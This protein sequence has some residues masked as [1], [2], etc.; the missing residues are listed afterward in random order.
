[1]SKA[2]NTNLV[3]TAPAPVSRK[4]N[5]QT[6]D[7]FMTNQPS[8]PS[9]LSAKSSSEPETSISEKPLSQSVSPDASQFDIGLHYE[10][11]KT[12]DDAEK[13]RL[14]S[15]IWK[16]PHDFKFP[17]NASARKFQG[18]WL[19][20]FPWLAYSQHLDG[21]FCINCVFFASPESSLNAYKMQQL[22]NS[23]FKTWNKAFK[24][25]RD[26]ATKSPMHQSFIFSSTYGAEGV[27]CQ[28]SAQPGSTCSNCEKS[29][30]AHSD[31][32]GHNVSWSP[33]YSFKRTS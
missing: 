5:Q 15:N 7:S 27:W 9:N 13:F 8:E 29:S 16:P 20:E 6:L 32:R 12:L 3:L 18:Q 11:A 22:Y 17:P 14:F 23:P 28:Y 4:A 31:C 24:K 2:P 19:K 30:Q 1:M 33:E 21:A 26:H 25:F 10:D